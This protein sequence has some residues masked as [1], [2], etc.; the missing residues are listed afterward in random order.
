[1]NGDSAHGPDDFGGFFFRKY[2][3]VITSDVHNAVL[4]FFRQG[5]LL[6]N[7]NS[8]VVVLI[9]KVKGV[10]RTEQYRPIVLANFQFKIIS[11][12]LAD[13]LA[14]VAPKIISENKRGFVKGRTIFDCICVTY[15]AVNLLDKKAFGGQLAMKID[16]KKLLTPLTGIF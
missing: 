2:W 10:E 9:P 12:V 16:I 7:L 4:Q 13:R 14:Q 5:R 11:K 3:D 6:P 8:N 15:E 1:M